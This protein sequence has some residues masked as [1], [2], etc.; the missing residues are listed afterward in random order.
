MS[1]DR[2]CIKDL[3]AGGGSA[4][5]GDNGG[6]EHRHERRGGMGPDE[7]RTREQSIHTRKYGGDSRRPASR[8]GWTGSGREI[9]RD[10]IN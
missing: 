7:K 2:C 4:N 6:G 10:L 8:F 1:N 9:W 5:G 3:H